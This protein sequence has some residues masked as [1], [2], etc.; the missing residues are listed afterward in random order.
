MSLLC[1][2]LLDEYEGGVPAPFFKS[3]T[4][5][6]RSKK[7]RGGNILSHKRI[8]PLYLLLTVESFFLLRELF[9]RLLYALYILGV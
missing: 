6:P 5:D 8:N 2:A 9:L 7:K 3:R 1:K 4:I